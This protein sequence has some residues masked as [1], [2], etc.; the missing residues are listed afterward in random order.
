MVIAELVNG[1]LRSRYVPGPNIDEYVVWYQNIDTSTDKRA[2]YLTDQLG[3]TI[4]FSGN[5]GRGTRYDAYGQPQCR[6]LSVHG[7]V[8]RTEAGVC[9]SIF[10]GRRAK[11]RPPCPSGRPFFRQH[12]DFRR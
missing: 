10:P 12:H 6:A 7:Q 2:W 3:S 9:P 1:V 11:L 4:A 8:W 5:T